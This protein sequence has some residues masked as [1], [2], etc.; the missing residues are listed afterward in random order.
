MITREQL[1]AILPHAP[2][3]RI[4]LFLAPLNAAM[5]GYR[6][7]T[8]SRQAAFVAQVGH[9][10]G[11]LQYVRELWGPTPTQ[12]AYENRADLGNTEPGDGKRFMGRGLIQVTGRANY[13]AC[14]VALFGDD[15]LLQFPELLEDPRYACR[16]AAWFWQQH[17][18]NELADAG[19]FKRITKIIN[20]GFT[21]YDERVELYRDACAALGV[22]APTEG[23]LV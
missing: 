15:R 11:E 20:G 21:H 12:R 23:A 7:D 13:R 8:P 3:S 2:R 1:V 14:S 19:N 6:I 9:E 18:L 17:G 4:D 22:T 16:S 5:I 10:S